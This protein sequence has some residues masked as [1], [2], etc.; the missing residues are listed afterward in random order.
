MRAKHQSR[1]G[2][3]FGFVDAAAR[4][5]APLFGYRVA[6]HGGTALN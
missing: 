5:N 1:Y 2:I 4:D 3:D 6:A